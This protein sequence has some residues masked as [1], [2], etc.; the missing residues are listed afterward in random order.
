VVLQVE[1]ANAQLQ[2]CFG[3]SPGMSEA[4]PLPPFTRPGGN[5]KLGVTPQ[6]GLNYVINKNLGVMFLLSFVTY[7]YRRDVA[8]SFNLSRGRGKTLFFPNPEIEFNGSYKIPVRKN[9]CLKACA[10]LAASFFSNY[11]S[12]FI[13]FAN[14]FPQ[15]YGINREN[16]FYAVLKS[17]VQWKTPGNHHA[18]YFGCD[19]H[20][21]LKKEYQFGTYEGTQ[22]L[23]EKTETRRGSYFSL[24]IIIFIGQEKYAWKKSPSKN[25]NSRT[26]PFVM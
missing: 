7:G 17:G 4:A 26:K 9:L 6:A 16:N 8:D 10:G 14:S 13:G 3:L 12:K 2:F 5:L 23:P 22:L 19:Y 21:G 11:E 18:L 15:G 24:N 20:W 25:Q 1:A